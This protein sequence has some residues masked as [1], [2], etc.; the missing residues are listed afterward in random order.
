[1]SRIYADVNRG[2]GKDW[3]DYENFTI[4]WSEPDRY[5]V[6]QRVGGG[7]YSEV[8]TGMDMANHERCIIKVLK[9]VAPK[10]IKREIKVLRNLTGG[11]N[12]VALLDVVRDPSGR[13]HSLVMEYVDNVEWKQLYMS[14]TEG[15]IKHYTFQL[16]KALDFVHAHGIMHRDVKPGNVMVDARTR[17]LRLID[18]GLAEFYHPSTDYHIRVGSRYYKAPELLVGYRQYDYSLDLWSLGC[19]FASMIFRKEHFF[20][21]S[22]NDDQ[23][24]KI[25]KCLGT[26]RFD[27]YLQ[28]YCIHFETEHESLLSNY[29]RQ[30]WT[31]Y[32]NADNQVYASPDALDLLDKLLRYDHQERLTARECQA[33]VYFNS[34]RLEAH[35]S[36]GES[37]SSDSGFYSA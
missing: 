3:Y 19:M 30:L 1:M 22:D 10:K 33:H 27:L 6:I 24:L 20:R 31:R 17:K 34:V 28:K 9:P 16:L 13:Y 21:G 35:E 4:E 7:R 11:P 25:L 15:D 5:E 12:V 26:E 14:L 8:F 37:F 18:W 36:K 32:I 23:L 2:L 29:P